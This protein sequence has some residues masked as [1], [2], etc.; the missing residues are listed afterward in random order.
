MTERK[1]ELRNASPGLYGWALTVVLSPD[2][3]LRQRTYLLGEPTVHLQRSNDGKPNAILL[4]DPA[5]SQEGVSLR[6]LGESIDYEL[7][8]NGS[9]NPVRVNGRVV[10]KHHLQ[11]ND[12]I[13]IGNTLLVVD[14]PS[15][16]RAGQ[17]TAGGLDA[18]RLEGLTQRLAIHRSTA[19]QLLSIDASL[20][21]TGCR[22]LLV[23]TP[24]SVEA[25]LAAEWCAE[26][27]GLPL[28]TVPA[29]DDDAPARLLEAP[30]SE[31][32]LL[33]RLDFA[34]TRRLTAL[35]DALRQRTEAPVHSLTVV[36]LPLELRTDP[37]PLLDTLLDLISQFELCIPPL[38]ERRADILPALV[39]RVDASDAPN[40]GQPIDVDFAE[41]MLCYG[42]PGELAELK[43]TAIWMSGL[44]R[45]GD[46]FHPA[47]LPE[48]MRGGRVQVEPDDAPRPLDRDAVALAMEEC[49]GN[50]SAVAEHFGYSRAYFYRLL[51]NAGIDIGEIRQSLRS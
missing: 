16:P 3:G 2:R 10:R 51:R 20:L 24:G 12:V 35:G 6:R 44:L 15:P 40:P 41:H 34:P 21:P 13:R 7:V 48:P 32:V 8:D 1:T 22:C 9:R 37:P 45:R 17:D 46:T 33:E 18:R 27:L 50:V 23:W 28:R 26:S 11:A 39:D 25:R 29:V 14:H 5:V 19:G 30:A 31:V 49:D 42:W 4:C 47:L 36:S 43:R 38:S